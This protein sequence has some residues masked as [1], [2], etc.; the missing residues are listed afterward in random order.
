VTK[1]LSRI[2]DFADSLD[3]IVL[4]ANA[5]FNRQN[6]THSF[7]FYELCRH[8]LSVGIHVTGSLQRVNT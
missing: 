8:L 1:E 3:T 5:T 4:E 2:E 6:N 7:R